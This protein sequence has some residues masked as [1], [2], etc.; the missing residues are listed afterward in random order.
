MGETGAGSTREGS[1]ARSGIAVRQTRAWSV[2]QWTVRAARLGIDLIVELLPRYVAPFRVPP[3]FVP[4]QMRGWISA[5][6]YPS[7]SASDPRSEPCICATSSPKR[8]ERS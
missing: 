6:A 4:V 3:K 7:C 5:T 1:D 2:S 8:R